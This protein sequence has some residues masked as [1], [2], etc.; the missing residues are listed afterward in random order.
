MLAEFIEAYGSEILYSILTGVATY[1]G[2]VVKKLY[3]RY[4]DDQTKKD[5]I[6]TVVKGVEQIYKDKT[7][8]EK[9]DFAFDNAMDMLENKGITISELELRMMIESVVGEFND[10]FNKTAKEEKQ[11]G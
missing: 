2:L 7:G 9:L 8:E 4:A 10:V 6:K 3:K 11:D 1:I 5:V